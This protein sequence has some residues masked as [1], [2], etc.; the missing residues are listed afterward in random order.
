[1]WI[2]Q[3]VLY[4]QIVQGLHRVAEEKIPLWVDVAGECLY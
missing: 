2:L 4:F 3:G 1:M